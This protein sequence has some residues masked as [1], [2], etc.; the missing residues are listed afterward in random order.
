M[1]FQQWDKIINSAKSGNGFLSKQKALLCGLDTFLRRPGN[2]TRNAPHIRDATDLK[3]FMIIVVLA[4]VPCTLF[5]IWNT[6]KNAYL[7]IG[8]NCSTYEAF[9]EGLIHVLPLIIISYT[10]GGICET[11]FAQIRKHEIAEGFLVTGL[12]YPLICPPTISWWMF[13]CGIIF[14]I[15]IGKEVFGGTGMN[16]I[17]PALLSRAFLFFAYPASISG[18]DVWVVK[19]FQKTADGSL[20]PTYWTSISNNKIITFINNSENLDAISGQTPL[21]LATNLSNDS[22]HG[23]IN[24]NLIN[25]FSIWDNFIGKIPG[26]IGETSTLMCLL[27]A[28]VLIVAGVASWRIMISICIGALFSDDCFIS[29]SDSRHVP[30]FYLDGDE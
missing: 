5:G 27:G 14:G 21:S 26:S 6:G 8:C 19:P 22:I 3:R 29:C 1:F 20:I 15:I 17:N 30:C 10:V 16:I 12:L 9:L 7:S 4:L 11:I 25:V 23:N 13:A 28:I 2:V 24:N 18:D